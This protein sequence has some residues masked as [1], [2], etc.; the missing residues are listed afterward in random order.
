MKKRKTPELAPKH[1]D[2]LRA[3]AL[4]RVDQCLADAKARGEKRKEG[5]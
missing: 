4:A 2:R 3:E 1:P 5:K